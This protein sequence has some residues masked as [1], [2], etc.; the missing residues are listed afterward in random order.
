MGAAPATAPAAVA[1]TEPTADTAP[2]TDEAP[3]A[4]V[5]LEDQSYCMPEV[6]EKAMTLLPNEQTIVD[7]T[8]YDGTT[9]PESDK[10]L[11]IMMAHVSKIPRLNS[12]EF[13]LLENPPVRL[14]RSCGRAEFHLRPVRLDLLVHRTSKLAP[15][16]LRV[17]DKYWPG[18]HEV[19][20]LD[21]T[22][23]LDTPKHPVNTVVV[24]LPYDPM[25]LLGTPTR[26][27]SDNGVASNEYTNPPRL[28]VAGIFYRNWLTKE[29]KPDNGRE[30][31]ILAPMLLAWQNRESGLAGSDISTNWVLA[32]SGTILVV[33]FG[34]WVWQRNVSKARAP[35]RWTASGARV[36][37]TSCRPRRRSPRWTRPCWPRRRRTSWSIP[38]NAPSPTPSR[39]R[40]E[41]T[42]TERMSSRWTPPCDRRRRTSIRNAVVENIRLELGERSH[43]V[44][45]AAGLLRGLGVAAREAR[46]GKAGR[47][48]VIA[49]AKVSRL[50]G[51]A[52]VASLTRAG[53][54]TSAIRF[55]AGER[56]KTLQTY[57]R[58][59]NRLLT[60]RR[61]WIAQPSSSA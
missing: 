32:I 43:V 1:A 46:R 54:Q 24:L 26:T 39:Y 60:L 14:L 16:S 18:R 58:V 49:D 45:V 22:S 36:R 3:V 20:Q 12:A 29:A 8:A 31:Y 6:V 7:A 61:S 25:P 47:A 48:V 33:L 52:V 15:S 38:K 4:G 34:L 21:C 10:G 53:F 35:P 59:M 28:Q 17:W 9:P 56:N 41:W 42:P 50:Y 23:V 40:G 30:T 44:R 51:D 13:D 2:T 5:N 37:P 57:Q 11:A 19:W 55:P 27:T